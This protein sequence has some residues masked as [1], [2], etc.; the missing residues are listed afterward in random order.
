MS[1][2]P[3][4]VYILGAGCSAGVPPAGPGFPLASE[5]ISALEEFSK[6]LVQD[7]QKLIKSYIDA[8][9]GLLRQEGAQ[10]VDALV[11]RLASEAHDFSNALTPQERRLGEHDIKKAKFATAALFMDLERKAKA[12]GLPRYHNFLDELFGN[13]TNWDQASRN[14]RDSVLTFNYDRLFEMAF[15]S[16]F[17]PDTG[18]HNLYGKS[19]LN[20][21]LDYVNGPAIDVEPGRFGFLKLH[22]SVGIRAR[23]EAYSG[24]PEH[25]TKYDGLPGDHT[26]PINDE[27]FFSN[28]SAS[29]PSER[30]PEPL[31]VFPPEKPFVHDGTK[32][33]LTFRTYIQG[34]WKE[35][36]RLVAEATEIW[37]IGYRFAPMDREDVLGLMQSA[38]N[39]K[40]LV[41]QNR[42]GTAENICQYL[43]W[44]WLEPAN[45][46]LKVEAFP[47]CF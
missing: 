7:N 3:K 47:Q 1:S 15:I 8:T 30:D 43:R 36:H 39:C 13:S 33:L 12:T 37:A 4:T 20:S 10:T 23:N 32:T 18:L 46:D 45:L 31:I 28:A 6:T 2:E 19:L 34:V 17:K 22:G 35:A 24:G 25:Y 16:R 44:R 42:P 11:A 38:K 40:R 26:K 5:F 21:G 41:I 27:L 14:S 29:D 9:S